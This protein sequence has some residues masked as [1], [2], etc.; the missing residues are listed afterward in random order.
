MPREIR[1]SWTWSE[2]KFREGKRPKWEK[3]R[4]PRKETSAHFLQGARPLRLYPKATLSCCHPG[5]FRQ[6]ARMIPHLLRKFR[7]QE[8]TVPCYQGKCRGPWLYCQLQGLRG[9]IRQAPWQLEPLKPEGQK[10]RMR[11]RVAWFPL[12]AASGPCLP[13]G[14]C[15]CRREAFGTQVLALS[16]SLC[17]RRRWGWTGWGE[18]GHSKWEVLST[19]VC[20]LCTQ[21]EGGWIQVRGAQYTGMYFVYSMGRRMNPSERCSVHRY[22]LCVLNGKED[23]SKWEVLS[24]QVCTLCTQWEG[25][26]IQVRGAQYTGMYFVYSVGRRMNPSER[27]SVHRYVLCVLSGKEDESKWEVLSTQVCTLCTQWEGGWIQVRGAQYT[28]MYFVYSVGRRM[29]PSERCSVHRY[30]L[31][32]LSGKEDES[33]W[34]VFSTQVCTLCTQWEGGWIQRRSVQYTGMY[35]VYSVGRRMNPKEKCS[36]H[37]YVLC[38]LSGKENESKGEVFSTQVCTLCT[39]WEGEWIQRRSVQHTGS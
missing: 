2:P 3:H 31:C 20:T 29:N 18:G 22:V 38:V 28:G 30:V 4:C 25:G 27:C 35:F 12:P 26:W 21:W 5:R 19:Q 13:A 34:E 1:G 9:K 7:Q 32:V 36:V 15:R 10:V 33:K 16:Y 11:R 8:L 39:Q 14:K 6:Q 23:E 37:R 24:T 17:V